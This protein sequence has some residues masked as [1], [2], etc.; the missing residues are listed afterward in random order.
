[1]DRIEFFQSVDQMNRAYD[2]VI[3]SLFDQF[4]AL[5]DI[6]AQYDSIRVSNTTEKNRVQFD[7]S[8]SESSKIDYIFNQINGKD[9]IMYVYGNIFEIST[10][11]IS[12]N[13]LQIRFSKKRQQVNNIIAN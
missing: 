8:C 5:Y 3:T 6:V 13:I 7:I 12:D 11:K 1:M 9:K 10:N 2:S 4:S